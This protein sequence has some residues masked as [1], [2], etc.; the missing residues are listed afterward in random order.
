M[1]NLN[2]TV[3][4]AAKKHLAKHL[5]AYKNA[6]AFKLYLKPDGCS[7]Y[8]FELEPLTD[9]EHEHVEVLDILYLAETWANYVDG[10]VIDIESQGIMGYKLKYALP[11]ARDYCGCGKSFQINK[12][13]G[14][15][16]A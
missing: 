5:Q 12:D 16:D 11:E 15:I 13:V 8:Q 6:Y 9:S 7:G 1:Q 10:L 3:T 4:D 2:I 14:T